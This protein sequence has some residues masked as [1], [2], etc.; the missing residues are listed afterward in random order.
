MASAN[1]TDDP[2]LEKHLDRIYSKPHRVLDSYDD[3]GPN[4]GE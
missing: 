4:D 1:H 2:K 3:S